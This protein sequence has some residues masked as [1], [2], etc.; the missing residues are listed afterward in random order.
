MRKIC[1][2]QYPEYLYAEH[3][4]DFIY[5]NCVRLGSSFRYGFLE[6][7]CMYILCIGG[8]VIAILEKRRKK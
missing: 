6:G 3:G 2:K 7:L 1:L 5:N 8:P 4:Y